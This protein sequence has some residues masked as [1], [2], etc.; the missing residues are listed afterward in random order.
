LGDRHEKMGNRGQIFG[1]TFSRRTCTIDPDNL[2][3]KLLM[4]QSRTE[5]LRL[6]VYLSIFV[7]VMF[8]GTFGFMLAENLSLADAAYF[9]IVT[10]AT[11]GYGDISPAT[12][13]GKLLAIILIVTGVG[14]FLGMLAG[15]TEIFLSRRDRDLRLQKL[16]MVV[17]LFF[18]EAGTRL[19]HLFAAAD[20]SGEYLAGEMGLKDDWGDRE[21]KRARRNLDRHPFKVDM[22]RIDLEKLRAFLTE[23]SD[24]L[25]RLLESP[26]ILEHE[27][28]T[29]LLI[30]L[31]HF[32]EELQYREGL[33][34]LPDSDHDHLRGDIH[35]V[36]RLAAVQ[37]LDYVR[38]LKGNYPFLFSLALRTNPFD[39]QASPVVRHA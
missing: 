39:P 20:G 3:A 14:T 12:D 18:S 34:A 15:A 27:S 2:P 19:L 32:K 10:I 28:F 30:A 25:V 7:G 23:K 8:I 6:I 11:V 35:R 38:R 31:L 16:Q 36:Y 5:K 33:S 21:F 4:S 13:V 24:L 26:Y 9:T 17:G 1:W 29:D 22:Q 37:W